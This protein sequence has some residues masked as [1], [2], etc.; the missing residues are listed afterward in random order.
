MGEEEKVFRHIVEKNHDDWKY[1][2]E[3]SQGPADN[4]K[5]AKARGD[6]LAEVLA[7]IKKQKEVLKIE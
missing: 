7:D 4:R 6:I 3:I 2:I 5:V 1:S